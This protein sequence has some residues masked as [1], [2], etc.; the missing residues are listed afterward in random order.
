MSGE[1]AAKLSGVLGS[2]YDAALEPEQWPA[3]LAAIR[4]AVGAEVSALFHW[5]AGASPV[6]GNVSAISGYPESSVATYEKYFSRI[7]IRRPAVT[8]LPPGTVYLDDRQMAFADVS[9]SEI[10]HDF[11][12]PRGLGH[13]MAAQF[14]ADPVRI[15]MLS[16]H[17]PLSHGAFRPDEVAF[18]ESLTPHL[19]R[20]LQL[21]RQLARARHVAQGMAVG[22]DHFQIAVILV[23]RDAKANACRPPPRTRA[24]GCTRIS[25]AP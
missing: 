19:I 18:F 21:Q 12:R 7:D 3:V 17:R 25:V 8:G 4:T 16:V 1:L 9:R 15:S 20:A 11:Y 24:V 10:F 14:F 22:L 6:T 5:D 23:D 2:L 13:C